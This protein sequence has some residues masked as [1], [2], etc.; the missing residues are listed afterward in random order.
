MTPDL[1]A[2]YIFECGAVV[3]VLAFFG[4]LVFGAFMD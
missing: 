2:E 4:V 1:L 3:L